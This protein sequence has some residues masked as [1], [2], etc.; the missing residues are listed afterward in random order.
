M[1]PT[2]DARNLEL[3]NMSLY[4]FVKRT[5]HLLQAD[6]QANFV[7]FVLTGRHQGKQAVVDSILNSLLN[8][9]ELD[10]RR[11]YDSLLGFES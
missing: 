8:D 7:Q 9:E 3:E 6:N 1:Q 10:V 11:Y 2:M 5:S 4:D